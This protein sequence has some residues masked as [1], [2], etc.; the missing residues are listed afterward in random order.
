MFFEKSFEGFLC[1]DDLLK[2]KTLPN[3]N[4]NPLVYLFA[5]EVRDSDHSFGYT[6][7]NVISSFD[8]IKRIDYNWLNKNKIRLLDGNDINNAYAALGELCSYGYLISAFGKDNV[9]VII[10]EKGTP[11]PDFYICGDNGERVYIEV[12]TVQINGE[13]YAALKEFK[14]FKD[15]PTNQRIKVRVHSVV[16][17]GRHDASCVTE[18]VI[19]KLCQIK[20]DEKQFDP[21]SPSVLWVD[22]QEHHVKALCKRAFSSCPI[23]TSQ[24]E[25]YSNELWYALYGEIGM[26]IYEEYD[27]I[28]NLIQTPIM[29]HNGKFSSQTQSKIDA[30]I[31]CFPSATIIYQNPY[32]QKPIPEWFLKRMFLIRWFNFQGSKLNFPSNDL[33]E[34]LK[35]D[36]EIVYNLQK[37]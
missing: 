25:I 21:K 36:K 17:F 12:N 31:F 16:P 37:M 2:C 27:P 34:Q 11:T 8:I 32:S 19:H 7:H 14:S 26:P 35:I 30:V 29:R 18:N 15:R 28:F 24:E 4:D 22:L 13:E 33:K 23:I 1:E 20:N 10:P 5:K 3:G 6:R 9:N